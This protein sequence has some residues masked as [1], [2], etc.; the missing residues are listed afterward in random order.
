MGPETS[1]LVAC[2][3]PSSAA[4][5]RAALIRHGVDCPHSRVVSFELSAT[6]AA[7][8]ELAVIFVPLAPGSDEAILALRR[9]R[10]ATNAKIVAIGAASTPK[11]VLDVIHAGANDY[12][13]DSESFEA[14]LKALLER[15]WSEETARSKSGGVLTLASASG[16]A[17]VSIVAV[18]LAAELAQ[19]H[20][21]C[22]L[23]D[24]RQPCGDLQSLLNLKPQY[25]LGDVCRNA[26]ELDQAML[27]Q[28]MVDHACGISLLA[29]GTA[30]G[31]PPQ[32]GETLLR[33]V[34]LAR[35]IFS[36]VVID[37]GGMV[38][39]TTPSVMQGSD[40]A[41]IVVRL[42]VVSIV[43]TKRTLEYLREQG[44]DD[45]RILLLGNRCGQAGELRQKPAERAVGRRLSHCLP[46]DPKA[47]NGSIN[48]GSPALHEAPGSKLSK[49]I[50]RACDELFG[51]CAGKKS[52]A[53]NGGAGAA[54]LS[55]AFGALSN[56]DQRSSAMLE[57]EAAEDL[58][59]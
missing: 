36:H 8:H 15:L 30:F 23:L 12:V 24:F 35:T 43:K 47:V 42:D 5:I 22:A 38:N 44:V 4:R 13:D 18:N 57:S 31:A 17:G 20:G 51:P 39:A 26:A 45:E 59:A 19:R 10:A 46:D 11:D 16:G 25:A 34:Q 37:L 1:V 9:L 3:A 41:V 21:R 50:K 55:Y 27:R 29:S 7:E 40:L 53:T 56:Q 2:D 58:N 14:E 6:F 28:A 33:I 48:V 54:V 49:A 32:S 52:V